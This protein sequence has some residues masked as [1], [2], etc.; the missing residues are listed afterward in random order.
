MKIDVRS[1]TRGVPQKAVI[2]CL[3]DEK[4]LYFSKL[5]KEALDLAKRL[6]RDIKRKK[7]K[8]TLLFVQPQKAKT[9]IFFF[10]AVESI[11][12][13]NRNEAIKIIAF[14]ALKKA[15]EMGE[16]RI[17]F[18]LDVPE[19]KN[20]VPLLAEGIFLGNYRF[21]RYLSKKNNDSSKIE[22]ISFLCPSS[23]Q[24][25]LQ[26]SVKRISHVCQSVNHARDIVNEPGNVMTPEALALHART[27]AKKYKLGC[28][29]LGEKQLKQKGYNGL[30]TVGAGSSPSP[31]LIVLSHN[32]AK[33]IKN[34]HLCIIGKGVTFDTGGMCLKPPK[35]M[36]EMKTDMAGAASALHS[37]EA[38]CRLS[39]PVKMTAIVPAAENVIG[40][41][42]TLPGDIFKAKN[43]KTVHVI[44][45]DAEGRLIL[46]DALAMAETLSPTHIIDL[47]TLTGAC[48]VALGGSLS[49]LFGDTPAFNKTFLDIADQAG[50]PCWELPLWEE[51][52]KNL[53]CDFADI[54][55]VAN[56]R[57]AG[58]INAALFLSEFKPEGAAWIHLDIAGTAMK[59]KEWKYFRSGATGVGI[60]T[61]I[62][63][64]EKFSGK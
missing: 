37:I 16:T 57:Q 12:Y 62:R 10:A 36:W 64:A 23:L 8:S 34:K 35:G 41:R 43:G 31:R 61:I 56:L 32:P 20:L 54:N 27:L 3:F 39:L 50:E 58:A 13:F 52:K 9:S 17:S 60:R 38:A 29:I 15:E 33:A 21:D 2:V 26:V 47:A 7:A 46:T 55:N 5:P 6:Q 53:K 19:A 28:R 44:N 11:K 51:Y 48:I 40:S 42:T 22:S 25:K 63:L 59:E 18:L 24:R 14:Q 4:Q 49:G 1:I 45:T 30:L